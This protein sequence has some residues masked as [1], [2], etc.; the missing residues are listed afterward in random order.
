M[1]VVIAKCHTDLLSENVKKVLNRKLRFTGNGMVSAPLGY[2][3]KRDERGRGLIIVDPIKA[4]LITKIFEE[5]A[6][7]AYTLSEMVLKAKRWGLRSKMV[8]T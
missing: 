2:L 4:P 3:N 6:T 1:G 5:Y 8:I 7:G